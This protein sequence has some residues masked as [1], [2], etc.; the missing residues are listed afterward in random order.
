MTGHAAPSLG[1]YP[2]RRG[3]SGEGGIGGVGF[4][5]SSGGAGAVQ[6]LS[7]GTGVLPS[8]HAMQGHTHCGTLCV[9]AC[10]HHCDVLHGLWRKFGCKPSGPRG[11]CLG[12]TLDPITYFPPFLNFVKQLQG[13][14]LSLQFLAAFWLLQTLAIGHWAVEGRR[15]QFHVVNFC[16]PKVG[17][18]DRVPTT[19]PSSP[20]AQT[21]LDALVF[22]R[23]GLFWGPSRAIQGSY[24][25]ALSTPH[26][27]VSA[28]H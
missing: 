20:L 18:G 17:R 24:W 14:F 15:L 1:G 23:L 6:W 11:C 7:S 4:G 12:H 8:S 25:V 9:P 28:G 5:S 3:V 22:E 10:H 13:P 27:L 2:L 26:S 16:F 19:K 21:Q